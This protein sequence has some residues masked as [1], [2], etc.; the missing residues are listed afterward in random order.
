MTPEQLLLI[1]NIF[2][3]LQVFDRSNHTT[4]LD[5]LIR[6]VASSAAS[7]EDENVILYVTA[8]SLIGLRDFREFLEQPFMKFFEQMFFSIEIKLVCEGSS[9]SQLVIRNSGPMQASQNDHPVVYFDKV[10]DPA[11]RDALIP[12]G[13]RLKSGCY[14]TAPNLSSNGSFWADICPR[15]SCICG[16]SDHMDKSWGQFPNL[17]RGMWGS[18][19]TEFAK[20]FFFMFCSEYAKFVCWVLENPFIFANRWIRLSNSIRNG[21]NFQMR[22]PFLPGIFSHQVFVL[23]TLLPCFETLPTQDGGCILVPKPFMMI[24]DP[25]KMYQP[26][27]DSEHR[28]FDEILA[29]MYRQPKVKPK[30]KKTVQQTGMLTKVAQSLGRCGRCDRFANSI[31]RRVL[32]TPNEEII[33]NFK[34]ENLILTEKLLRILGHFKCIGLLPALEELAELLQLPA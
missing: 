29:S 33:R 12:A 25:R 22:M 6:A 9:R 19:I 24:I 20:E 27:K 30:S 3:L 13:A 8:L 15:C 26:I 4:L 10:C 2:G 5:A 28:S 17:G 23:R 14:L 11:I 31:L 7:E 32:H 16:N 21:C 34:D 1:C 18:I